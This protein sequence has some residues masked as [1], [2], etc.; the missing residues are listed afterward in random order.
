[1]KHLYPCPDCGTYDDDTHAAECATWAKTQT[2]RRAVEEAMTAGEALEARGLCGWCEEALDATDLSG[3]HD[4]CRVRAIAGSV[5]HQA[6]RCSC[7]GGQEGDPFGA[8]KREAA[9]AAAELFRL[10]RAPEA[11]E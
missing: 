3:F 10:L 5:G 8:T 7:F 2:R 9:R 11:V 6:H 1:V 4:E